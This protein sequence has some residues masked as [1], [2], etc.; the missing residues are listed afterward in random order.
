MTNTTTQ[1][2]LAEVAL[3]LFLERGYDRVPA[4][5][6]AAQAG[7]SRRTFFRHFPS[8]DSVVFRAHAGRVEAL[9]AAIARRHDL[10]PT[11]AVRAGCLELAAAWQEQ[12]EAHKRQWAIVQSSSTL[13]AREL[14][15]DRAFSTMFAEALARGP[16]GVDHK[17]VAGMLMGSIRSAMEIWLEGD[18]RESLVE[19]GA[20]ALTLAIDGVGM[21]D[22]ERGG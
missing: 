1:E 11:E 5:E 20:R 15:L 17:L 21:L 16:V 6:I 7:V 3:E 10:S 8:K 2:R 4:E 18:C 12:A 22:T 14:E 19:L 9:A 13:V